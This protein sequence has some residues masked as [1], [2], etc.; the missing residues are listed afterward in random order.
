MS[1]ASSHCKDRRL[2][3]EKEGAFSNQKLSRGGIH[4]GQTDTGP[5]GLREQRTDRTMKRILMAATAALGL[6]A[7]QARA[8]GFSDTWIGVRDGPYQSNVGGNP[9]DATNAR[10]VNKLVVSLGH[11]DVWDYGT[12]FFNVDTLF[13]DGNEAAFSGVPGKASNAGSTEFYAVYRA[14]LSPDKIFGLNTKFGPVAAINFEIGGDMEGENTQFA[15]AKKLFIAGPNIHFD[16]APA[17]FLNIGLH[18]AK[19]WNHNGFCAEACTKPGG[20]VSFDATGEFEFVWLYPLAFTGL[21]L[22]FRGFMNVI[23]PKGK[24]GFGGHTYTE[25]LAYPRLNL[26]LGKMVFGKPHK[27]DL[28]LAVELWEHKFGSSGQTPGS[29]E[30]SPQIGIEVHF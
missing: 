9:G 21:P 4:V 16:L 23:L 3:A 30:V 8:Q 29:N 12:N 20:P 10:N 22:D 27:P 19:E 7:G 6:I 15:P 24:D 5:I 26:D 2:A 17:G 25:I 14:Q 11:F 18:I 28:Y 13:S 1:I